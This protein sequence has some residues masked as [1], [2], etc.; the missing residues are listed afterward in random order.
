MDSTLFLDHKGVAADI[1][2]ERCMLEQA[3]KDE[4]ENADEVEK[5]KYNRT[6]NDMKAVDGLNVFLGNKPGWNGTIDVK[7]SNEKD[8]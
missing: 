4:R 7:F 5:H 6:V 3:R 2:K 1:E 8:Y